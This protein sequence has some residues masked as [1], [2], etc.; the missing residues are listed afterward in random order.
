MSSLPNRSTIRSFSKSQPAKPSFQT[1][2]QRMTVQ[3]Q[4][5]QKSTQQQTH[6]QVEHLSRKHQRITSAAVKA[7]KPVQQHLQRAGKIVENRMNSLKAK[8][9]GQI[10]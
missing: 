3:H 6:Q 8:V 2:L 4:E 1:P 7:E 9:N 5:R 10:K